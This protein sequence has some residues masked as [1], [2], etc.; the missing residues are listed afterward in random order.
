[1]FKYVKKTR[2]VIRVGKNP[3]FFTIIRLGKKT[4]VLLGFIKIMIY[5]MYFKIRMFLRER[6]FK[7]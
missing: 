7:L 1:M 4:W 6:K 3:G 2:D 5:A